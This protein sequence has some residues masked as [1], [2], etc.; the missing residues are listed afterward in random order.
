VYG[1]A[2]NA[3]DSA[4]VLIGDP[5][6]AIYA[7]R[8]ADIHTYL[9]A[10]RDTAGRHATLGT[11]FRSTQDMVEGVNR[12]FQQ[13]EARATGRGAFLFREAGDN[14][15]PFVPVQAHGRKKQWLVDGEPAAA[16]TCWW[17]DDGANYV[18]NMA[19]ACAT[20]IG[21]LLQLGQEG[22]AG[23]AEDG[24]PFQCLRPGDIAVLVNT[25]REARA[26]RAA[27]QERGVRSVY[28]SDQDSVFASAVAGDLQRLL[29]ACAEP[30]DDRVLRAALGTK[31]LDL[32][33]AELDD[34]NQDDEHWEA[35]VLQF[36]RYRDQWRAQGVLPMLRRLLHDFAVPQRLLSLA[37][38]RALTDVLHLAELLQ[39]AS[40]LLDGEHAL[41]RHLAEQRADISIGNESRLVR[42]ES[43]ADLLKVVTVHKSKGLEY[44]LVFLPFACAARTAKEG[45]LPLKWHDDEGTLRLSL[46]A[47]G[48][49]LARADDERLGEDLRKLYVALTRARYATWIG[50]APLKDFERT[51]VGYLLQGGAPLAAS[52]QARLGNGPAV[53]VRPAPEAAVV[54][55]EP[56][57]RA[58]TLAPERVPPR[59]V[60]EAWWIAS[61]SGLRVGDEIVADSL[62]DS[63]VAALPA[64]ESA[65]EATYLEARADAGGDTKEPAA[66]GGLHD[67]P[68]GPSPGSFLHA[69]LEWAGRQG[70][71]A[72]AAAPRELATF[73]ER[74]C[75]GRDWDRWAQPLQD[76]MQRW[77]AAPLDLSALGGTP[78]SPA[79]L[80]VQQVEMEFWFAATRVDAKALDRLVRAHTLGGAARPALLPQH[81]NGMLKGFIDLVFEHEG[82]YYVADYKSNRLAESDAGYTQSAM[83]AEVL[84]HRYELQYTLYLFALHRLLR[85]RLPDYDYERHVGGAVYLFLRGHAAPS[86]GLHLERPPKVLMEALDRLFSGQGAEVSA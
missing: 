40:A 1:I 63:E 56:R 15:L 33:W 76:W 45:D 28:L 55:Y 46:V 36:R 47:D 77:L 3:Q 14:P 66:A 9:A 57:D 35:R 37:E 54:R 29:Q 11:N 24:K 65:I 71:A 31:L 60:R 16:L 32:P 30:D 25:G 23:F 42:L 38:E 8:G 34:L 83:R 73:I 26:M 48:E 20:E 6:Q 13:A 10:R 27:L 85:A 41:V 19:A 79:Q 51:A 52:L 12:F 84:K 72:T 49:A 86:G 82:R 78:V 67:F 21:R 50:V 39:E 53:A 68:R 69:L 62:V 61:Y 64:P 74:R 22:R 58:A 18:Q 7:F 75:Q 43:D 44:P 17:R 80:H 59:S 2:R 81:L 4:V 5:K 70:F